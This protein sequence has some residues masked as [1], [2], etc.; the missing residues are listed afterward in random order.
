M[1]GATNIWKVGAVVLGAALLV[2]ANSFVPPPAYAQRSLT[3]SNTHDDSNNNETCM[4]S[5]MM[6]DFLAGQG[7]TDVTLNSPVGRYWQARAVEGDRVTLIKVDT[8]SHKIVSRTQ[9]GSV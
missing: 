4:T 7:Y 2:A 5:R 1:V 8:C 9:M 3:D 6:R